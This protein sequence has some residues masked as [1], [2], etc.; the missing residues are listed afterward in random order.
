M[1]INV[2]G[3]IIETERP[4]ESDQE[5]I[6]RLKLKEISTGLNEIEKER[7]QSLIEF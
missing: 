1:K 7:L 6:E 4:H 2:N 5:E 3:M